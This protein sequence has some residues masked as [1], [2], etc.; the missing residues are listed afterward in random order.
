MLFAV[1]DPRKNQHS[2]LTEILFIALLPRCACHDFGDIALFGRSKEA[3]LHDS[4]AGARYRATTPSAVPSYPRSEQL[5]RVFWR[6]T[7]AFATAA[8]PGAVALDGRR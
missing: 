6:F 1:D 2:T 4:G 7:E 3:L 8:A 5:R